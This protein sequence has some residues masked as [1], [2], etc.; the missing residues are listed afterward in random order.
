LTKNGSFPSDA[1][2]CKLLKKTNLR[3]QSLLSIQD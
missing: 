2:S 1:K 3:L